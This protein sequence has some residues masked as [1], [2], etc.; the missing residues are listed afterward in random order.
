MEDVLRT[1]AR[2]LAEM[3][4]CDAVIGWQLKENDKTKVSL[5]VKILPKR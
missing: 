2:S 1:M 3:L 4:R 5:K